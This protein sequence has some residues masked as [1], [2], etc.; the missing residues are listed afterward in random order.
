ML[1]R[2]FKRGL[3]KINERFKAAFKARSNL[4]EVKLYNS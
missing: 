4:N 1:Q 2:G 3:I